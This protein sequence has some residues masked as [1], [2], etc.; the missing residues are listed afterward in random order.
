MEQVELARVD[1]A[2]IVPSTLFDRE[3]LVPVTLSTDVDHEWIQAFNHVRGQATPP[4]N[5]FALLPPRTI[6]MTVGVGGRVADRVGLLR[7]LVTLANVRLRQLRE[8]R[9]QDDD[10]RAR[11]AGA[12]IEQIAREL[13][14][15]GL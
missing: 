13:D 5:E 4:A 15:L 12:R 1:R 3:V 8:R 7:Q 9:G 2:S 10:E 14:D 11:A 6:M